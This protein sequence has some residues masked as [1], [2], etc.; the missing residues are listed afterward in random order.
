MDF[1]FA[2]FANFDFAH[3]VVVLVFSKN[4]VSIGKIKDWSISRAIFISG[5]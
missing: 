3:Y 2:Y 5:I 4:W 1:N